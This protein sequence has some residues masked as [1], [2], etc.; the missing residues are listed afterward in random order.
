M[1]ER[2]AD[3]AGVGGSSPPRPTNR[4]KAMEEKVTDFDLITISVVMVK[5]VNYIPITIRVTDEKENMKARL[6]LNHRTLV[7]GM[8]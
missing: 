4:R 2:S 7:K 5:P 1:V 8:E 6:R 3:N